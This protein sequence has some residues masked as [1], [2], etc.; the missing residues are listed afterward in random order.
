MNVI[1]KTAVGV[2]TALSVIVSGASAS[3]SDWA[4]ESVEIAKRAGIIQAGIDDYKS[5]ITRGEIAQLISDA[6]TNIKGDEAVFDDAPFT[7]VQGDRHIA[8]VHS[9][10]IMNGRGDGIFDADAVTTRQEMAKI[11]LTFRAVASGEVI[12]ISKSDKLNFLDADTISDWAVPY[13]AKATSDGIINGYD[14]GTFGATLPVTWEQAVALVVRSVDLNDISGTYEI[15]WKGKK[16]VDNYTVT[17]TEHRMSRIE[18]EIP[19]NT[20]EVYQV[21]GRSMSFYPNPKRKY[22]VEI[23]GD[24]YEDLQEHIFPAVDV[25]EV[26]DKIRENYP[27]TKEEADAL[28]EGIKEA[29]SKLARK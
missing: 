4:R 6:Y 26:Q 24:G 20:P 14:D 11:I 25:T 5:P 23:T 19:P 15:S 7:D 16:G 18:G 21:T 3:V 13:V 10:G 28:I 9:L 12:N 8:L 29:L 27:T 17:I 2:L 1:V 22:T